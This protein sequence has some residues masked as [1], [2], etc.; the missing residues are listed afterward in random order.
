MPNH[1]LSSVPKGV[2]VIAVA[3]VAHL[4]IATRSAAQGTAHVDRSSGVFFKIDGARDCV[5]DPRRQRLYVTD[6]QHLIVLDAKNRKTVKA[7]DLPGKVR[8]CD[9]TPDFKH[10]AVAPFSG[11]FLF[12]IDL[13]DLEI[14]QVRFKCDATETGVYD[15]CVGVDGSVLFS[16][17]F[18]NSEGAASG[19]VKLRRFDPISMAVTVVGGVRM[20]T[21]V[22]ASGDRRYAAVAEGNISSGPL[23]LY[24]FEEKKLR[25]VTQTQTFNYE[26]ACSA[27]ARYFARPHRTGCDL[28]D[29]GGARL[30]NVAGKSVICAAF[31]PKADRLFVMRDGESTIQEYVLPSQ[32][33]ANEYLLQKAVAIAGKASDHVVANI[34]TNRNLSIGHISRVHSVHYKAFESGRIRT[35][36]DGERVFAVVPTGVYMFATKEPAKEETGTKFKVIEAK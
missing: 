30:G 23:R 6:D 34:H 35:S 4:Q 9:I 15:L 7:I 19:W 21:V 13:D 16:M 24:D 28:Y 3:I 5:F 17:V 32:K 10:L 1:L 14:T 27:G 31:H 8:A 12:W 20:D 26:I 18:L 22:S 2:C 36:E 29:S 25:D 33:L 11:Q